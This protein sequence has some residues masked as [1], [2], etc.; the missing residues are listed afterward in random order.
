MAIL[1]QYD[2]SALTA[3]TVAT[4]VTGGSILNASLTSI[5][6]NSSGLGYSNEP[7]YIVNPTSGAVASATAIQNNSYFT[8]SISPASGYTI[9][10]TNLTFNI[11]RGG[12]GTPRGYDVRSSVDSYATTLGTADVATVRP[13]YT[14]VTID[15]SAAGFQT[16][17]S[18]ITFRI[19]C[20]CPSE[21][22]SLDIDA[23]TINGTVASSGT[24]EQEGFRFRND[25]G[26]EA[27]A[28]W[29][30]VQD[31]NIIQEKNTNVRLRVLLNS[32]LNRGSELYQLEI[33]EVGGSTWT[34]LT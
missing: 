29:L 19:N 15:L 6:A 18:T 22:N 24:V 5:T 23:L 8:F 16:V 9:S 3:S 33:R 32:T 34:V 4:N 30:A 10:L 13:T 21:F 28:T 31:T 25:D 27:T 12:A 7:L 20:Y 26:T 2:G 11:G 17:S 14:A 1:L